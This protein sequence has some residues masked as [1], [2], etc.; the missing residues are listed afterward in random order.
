MVRYMSS[1]VLYQVHM[2]VEEDDGFE[3][4]ARKVFVFCFSLCAP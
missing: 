2:V 1:L 4:V 3:F